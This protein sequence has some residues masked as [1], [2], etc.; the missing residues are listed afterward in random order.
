MFGKNKKKGVLY[1]IKGT[2]RGHLEALAAVEQMCALNRTKILQG[3]IERESISTE[4]KD[5]IVFDAQSL[6]FIQK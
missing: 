2:E 6:A 1:Q 3:I 4:E 5:G